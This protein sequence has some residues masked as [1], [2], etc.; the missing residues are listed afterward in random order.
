M[1][2]GSRDEEEQSTGKV[3]L[4]DTGKDSFFSDDVYAQVLDADDFMV[5]LQQLFDWGRYTERLLTVP[6]PG[7]DP[8]GRPT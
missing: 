7:A 4:V 8:G 2:S 5:A 6:A 1:E 3:R